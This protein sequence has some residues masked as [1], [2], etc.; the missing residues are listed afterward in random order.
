MKPI[1]SLDLEIISFET[2]AD[3]E[4]W[5]DQNHNVSNGIWLRMF[6]KDS[7]R[8]TVYYPEAL[9]GALCHGWIDGQRK[10]FDDESFIQRFTPRRP[11]SLWSKINIGHVERLHQTGKMRPG[12]VAAVKAAKADG[13]WHAAYDGPKRAEIPTDFLAA[14]AKNKRALAF[15]KT[16]NKTNQYSIAWRLQTARKP[17]IREKRLKAIVEMMKKGEKFH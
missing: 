12:G 15:F 1:P 6:K 9:D 8:K 2:A 10:S 14:V 7:G 17:E 3:W 4:N 13:R 16:L 5:L 11:R